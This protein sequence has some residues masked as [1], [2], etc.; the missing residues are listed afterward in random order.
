MDRCLDL[1]KPVVL[2]IL[3]VF[4]RE[5]L[6]RPNP[7]PEAGPSPPSAGVSATRRRRPRW[8]GLLQKGWHREGPRPDGALAV[9]LLVEGSPDNVTD[10][11]DGVRRPDTREAPLVT[12]GYV[13]TELV[14][15]LNAA[16]KERCPELE[17]H[18]RLVPVVLQGEIPKG[19]DIGQP[20]HTG[21]PVGP[22]LILGPARSGT[23]PRS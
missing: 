22:C 17:V 16:P 10:G 1:L 9:L 19:L 23:G 2:L 14:P 7:S 21:S 8:A 3:L 6:T 12:L 20:T 18:L 4:D 11:L 15:R 13:P 5:E